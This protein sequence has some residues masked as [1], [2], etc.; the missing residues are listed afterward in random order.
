M[1]YEVKW[2]ETAL[3]QLKKL[4]KCISKK[5]VE[6]VEGISENPFKFVK[7]LKGINLYTLRVGDYRAILAIEGKSLIV[8]VLEVGHRKKL[9]QK[10]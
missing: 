3:K 4:E 10:F 7:K 5:I 1:K 2:T 6:K 8:F 9:Y